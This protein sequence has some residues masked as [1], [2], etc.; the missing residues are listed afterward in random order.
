[1]LL[2]NNIGNTSINLYLTLKIFLRPNL[3]IKNNIT[4]MIILDMIY[5]GIE[6][7]RIKAII[8]LSVFC[9]QYNT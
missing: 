6:L 5:M 2:T 4:K 8:V 9:I 3:E 7:L 1:M